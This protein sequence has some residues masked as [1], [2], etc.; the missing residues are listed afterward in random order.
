MTSTITNMIEQAAKRMADGDG[1]SWDALA[2]ADALNDQFSW[3][4]RQ[5]MERYRRLAKLALQGEDQ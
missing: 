5:R 3:S 2:H 4:A 1:H